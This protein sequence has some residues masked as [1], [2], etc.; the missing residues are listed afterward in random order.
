MLEILGEQKE[1]D[2]I[3]WVKVRT[4]DGLEGWASAAALRTATPL[5]TIT[6]P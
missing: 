6:K 3:L 5:A 2:G 1:R 4:N